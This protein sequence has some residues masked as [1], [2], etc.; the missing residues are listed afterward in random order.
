M[1]DHCKCVSNWT[2]MACHVYDLNYVRVMIIVMCDMWLKDVESQVL[3]WR[4]LVKVMKANS[5][6]MP[7]FKGFIVFKQ[8]IML[9]TLCLAHQE[10]LPNCSITKKKLVISIGFNPWSF[11]L[12][13]LSKPHL[14]AK[15][16]EICN[17]Y[18]SS[19][20]IDETNANFE[21]IRSW[22]HSFGIGSRTHLEDLND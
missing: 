6:D 4:A 12:I 21:V 17:N 11:T 13:G 18:K 3:I 10:S 14:G 1:F 7:Q 2:T 9:F 19:K 5:V 15:H 16:M 20:T 8:T 22:W